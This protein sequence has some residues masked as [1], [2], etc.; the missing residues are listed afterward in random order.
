M[1]KIRELTKSNVVDLNGAPHRAESIQVKS[2]SARGGSSIY[3]IRFRN[4]ISHQK[5]DQTFKGEDTIAEMDVETR[6]VQF[7]YQDG[8]TYAFMDDETY[9]QHELSASDLEDA[10]PF[11]I[12]DMEGIRALVRDGRVLT[13]VMPDSVALKVTECD[14]S[15]KGASATARTKPATLETGLIIQVPEYLSAD[16]TVR[17]DTRNNQFLGRA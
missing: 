1:I 5:L 13:I 15:I 11:L 2:P 9:E 14:P 3:K 10:L 7:A 4:L 6:D 12:E 16:E 8:D 17:V